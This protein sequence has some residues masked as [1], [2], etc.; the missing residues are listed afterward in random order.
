MEA[1][2]F[3]G[4]LATVNTINQFE[5]YLPQGRT[6]EASL[7]VKYN[8]D[9]YGYLYQ[10]HNHSGYFWVTNPAGSIVTSSNVNTSN[11]SGDGVV[12]AQPPMVFTAPSSGMYTFSVYSP[13]TPPAIAGFH[14]MGDSYSAFLQPITL[15]TTPDSQL[16]QTRI[17]P[18]P[19]R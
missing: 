4:I 10:T 3:D 7:D 12:S 6:F 17:P 11:Q 9:D 1:T 8:Y 14:P 19:P 2:R 13:T 5:V 15:N 16:N 18:T